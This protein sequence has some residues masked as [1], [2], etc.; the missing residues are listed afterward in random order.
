MTTVNVIKFR[1]KATLTLLFWPI[2]VPYCWML[3]GYEA[4]GGVKVALRSFRKGFKALKLGRK[5][6]RGE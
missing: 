1:I 5:L 3:S 2:V 4:E 6:R